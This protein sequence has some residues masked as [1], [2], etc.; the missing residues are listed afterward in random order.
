[1]S[2]HSSARHRAALVPVTRGVPPPRGYCDTVPALTRCVLPQQSPPGWLSTTLTTVQES[3]TADE[4]QPK[5]A[6]SWNSTDWTLIACALFDN[7]TALQGFGSPS[8]SGVATTGSTPSSLPESSDE[9]S[10]RD[11]RDGSCL[12]PIVDWSK[13]GATGSVLELVQSGRDVALKLG[14]SVEADSGAESMSGNLCAE[15]GRDVVLD[16]NKRVAAASGREKLSGNVCAVFGRGRD[17]DWNMRKRV[18]ADSGLEHSRE[19]LVRFFARNVGL[20][21]STRVE[22]TGSVLI[23]IK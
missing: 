13:H 22:V 14:N 8:G 16:L 9:S 15:F 1:M 3:G 17:I 18:E 6:R 2:R 4:L 19:I 20:N 12:D 7:R 21:L 10:S 11:E 5:Y 23:F